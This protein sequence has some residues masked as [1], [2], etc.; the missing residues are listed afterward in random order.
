MDGRTLL[1]SELL[2]A[3]SIVLL[4]LSLVVQSVQTALKK[5][6]KLNRYERRSQALISL[7]RG[8]LF[9]G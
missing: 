1:K 5:M 2:P 4:G 8:N 7:S 3:I 9:S 6:F